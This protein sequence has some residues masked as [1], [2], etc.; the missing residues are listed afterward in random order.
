MRS[1]PKMMMVLAAMTAGCALPRPRA[2]RVDKVPLGKVVVYQN[3]VA[4]YQRRARV[5][6]GKVL[7]RVPRERVDDFLKSLTVVDARTQR[8]LPV[9]FPRQQAADAPVIDMQLEVAD[10]PD[11]ADV[12][13]TY[14]TDAA[15]WKPSYRLVL[16]DDDAMLEGWAVVDNL[17]GED[18]NDVEVG[19]GS[20]AAM[21]FRY[22]LWSVRT[23]D[24]EELAADEAFAVAPPTAVSP[25]GGAAPATEATNLLTL[26]ADEIRD[27]DRP[28]AVPAG[29]GA[30][31]GAMVPMPGQ[32]TATSGAIQ[33]RVTDAGSGESLAGVT[34]VAS[35]KNSLT[36]ITEMDGTYSFAGLPP[37]DYL[38]TFFYGDITIERSGIRVAANKVTPVFQKL[39]SAA[40]ASETIVITDRAPMIDQTSTTQGITIRDEYT[41]NR[42]PVGRSFDTALGTSRGSTG[43][44]AG[45]SFSGGS[46]VESAYAV[47]GGSAAP[48]PRQAR[49]Q[50]VRLG[51]AKL[52]EV[53]A[54]LI[55]DRRP[56]VV[57]GF[58]ASGEPDPE[59][60]A[61]DRANLVRNQLIDAGVAPGRIRAV[62]RGVGAKA[63][64][65]IVADT[66]PPESPQA[67]P[68]T[69]AATAD[70]PPVGEGY[71]AT[72]ARLTVRNGASAMV[73][74][75]HQRTNGREAYLYDAAGERGNERYAFKA[76]R[77]DNP[78]DDTLAAGPITVY[79]DGRYVGEGLTEA[80]AP[81]AAV[82]IPYALDRQV[83]VER[84]GS[85]RDELT[86][87]VTIQRGVVT[88]EVQH[89]RATALTITSRLAAPTTVYVR[90]QLEPGWE[91]L[92]QALPTERIGGAL[93]VAVELPAG[94]TRTVTLEEATPLVR[95]LELNATDTLAQLAVFV[96]SD[97]PA[98]ALREPIERVLAVHRELIDTVDKIDSLRER[99]AEYRA[100]QA[101][102]TQQLLD[103]RK[104]KTA[105]ALSRELTAKA[106]DMATRVQELTVDLVAA[107]DRVML[108]RVQFADA[109]ADLHLAPALAEHR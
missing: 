105:T 26:D 21:S 29:A 43:D 65:Q 84:D 14:V 16:G 35:G 22:D 51:D 75:L 95:R 54:G 93:L 99:A 109:L 58:A 25:Y 81:R 11:G 66:A 45:V 3:G 4:Y 18:W 70:A 77:L 85:T 39:N 33:G 87:L 52:A 48:D 63:T 6:Q 37:G 17:S 40:S 86:R 68:R 92:P 108:L 9:M 2:V 103:L 12:L 91:L 71:F 82:V 67:G 15:A 19:V 104:V 46:S 94:A 42:P 8:A 100:R 89:V 53:A 5:E 41:H 55:K 31:S 1:W 13:M 98:P 28:G 79:G 78:T 90:H 107:Q 80:V 76:V 23:V 56:V 83:V 96:H 102:L 97:R 101:E 74:V 72:G 47:A 24:R 60:A 32:V 57:E 59:A 69:S 88:A 27:A 36:T 30:G 61:L 20:S 64:V 10:A 73:A 38:V 7:V 62:S 106:I 49:F 34:V 44:T 50:A